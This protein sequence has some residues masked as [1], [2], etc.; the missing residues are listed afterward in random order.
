VRRLLAVLLCLVPLAVVAAGCGS[1]SSSSGNAKSPLDEALG[2]LPKTAPFAVAIDTDVNDAQWKSLT[3]NLKKFPF[4]SEIENQL[5]SSIKSQ[6]FDFNKDLKPLL[7]NP[8]VVGSPTVRGFTAGNNQF[9]GAVK[10]NDKGKLSDLLKS[11]V[12]KGDLKKDGDSNGATLYKSSS[13]DTETAQKDDVLLVASTRAELI[14]ALEQRGRDD[15]LTESDFNSSLTG[16]SSNALMRATFDVEQLINQGRTAAAAR[17]V[18][19]VSALRTFGLAAMSESD[20]IAV[21]FNLKSDPSQLQDSDLPIAGGDASPPV[22]TR[23]GEISFGIRGLDQTERFAESVAQTISP[24]SYGDFKRAKA[25]LRSQLGVDVDRDLIAQLSGNTTV[26]LDVA[27]H[28]AARSEPKNPA[29]FTKT[30]T[31]FSKVAPQF[32]T[33]AGLPGAKLTRSHGIYKLSGSNGKTIYYGM[34]GNSFVVSNDAARLA[35]IAGGSPAPVPGAKGAIAL[36]T[37]AGKLVA[38]IV[39]QATGGG[40][41]GAFSGSVISGPI[42]SLTGWVNSSTSGLTGHFKLEIR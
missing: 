17:R 9:I 16:L 12:D 32:A 13:D 30:L 8:F 27:G 23:P 35:T 42:G 29:A 24:S 40:L 6:G 11:S 20:G 1:S 10:V 3:A 4:A 34:V 2:Y 41:G 5:Q 26:S 31:K 38:Q 37:D 19:W 22:L 14:A 33:G 28:F 18:K 7:G 39:Q 36:N 21:D 15:R 25:Q